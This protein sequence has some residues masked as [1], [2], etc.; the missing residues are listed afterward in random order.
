[1][2]YVAIT[3]A[4]GALLLAC[5]RR[6][7]RLTAA[8]ARQALEESAAASQAEGLTAASVDLAT[9][10]TFG[11]GVEA[12]VSE[13]RA[14]V[15]AQ[16]PCAE[17]SVDGATLSVEYGVAGSCM[18]RGHE[19]SGTARITVSANAEQVLV[20]HEWV[21]V[22][23]GVVSLDGTATVTWDLA[24]ET[25]RVVHATEWTSLRTGRVVSGEGDRLQRLL[26]GE[27]EQGIQ[28]DGWRSW[29][30][31]RGSWELAIDGVEM[32]WADPVPQ[33]G[34]YTL[35]T[36]F[37]KTVSMT[38]E[39]ADADTIAVTVASGEREFEFTVSKL[40]AV[41]QSEP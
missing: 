15:G 21:D 16:L 34:G 3:C 12:A 1:M 4:L 20:E 18:Y 23:N 22:S 5:P 38:F 24:A 25:R 17:V 9:G 39:R 40:G 36:P 33:A 26:G 31:E 41:Q 13:L 8:E 30:G 27:A 32:R 37:G 19:L 11:A 28:V 2:K 35:S 7:G 10:F 29:E 14:F 6:E